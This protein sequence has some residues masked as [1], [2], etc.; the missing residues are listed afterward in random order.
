MSPEERAKK[1]RVLRTESELCR[2]AQHVSYEI[3]MLIHAGNELGGFHSSPM[4]TPGGNDKNIALE[5]FLL[6]FR[7]LRAFL[8]PSLQL[9]TPDDVIASDFLQEIV[10]RD[11]VD[12]T[13]LS[14]DKQ[15]LD[16]ML[17]HLSYSRRLF[18]DGGTHGWE[19]ARMLALMLSQLEAFCTMLSAA[20]RNWFPDS[21]WIAK[22]KE[23]A[24]DFL[25][26]GPIEGPKLE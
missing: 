4:S 6:H 17:A 8:C 16:K 21:E 7:N 23:L 22:S 18:I 13:V 24:A 9:T 2:A 10:P 25:L 5:S 19:V 26:Q 1:T 14:T 20:H 12:P 11:V 3:N 15:R